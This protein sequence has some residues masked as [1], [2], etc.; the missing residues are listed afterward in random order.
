M[1]CEVDMKIDD[2]GIKEKTGQLFLVLGDL[3][4]PD[5]LLSM[6]R[7]RHIGGVLFRPDTAENIC[8]RYS[9]LDK[10]AK[11]PLLKAAN[12]ESGADGAV[13]D[14]TLFA[15]PMQIAATG[16]QIWA[17]RMGLS[18]V[19]ES[20]ASGVNITFSPV[21]DIDMNF[22]NPITNTRTFGDDT[23]RVVKMATAYINA[24]QSTGMAACVKHFPGDGVDFRDHHLHPTVNSLSADEWY[25]SYGKV[26]K[27]AI[28]AGVKCVMAGHIIQPNLTGNKLPG[29]LNK[30]LLQGILRG[31]LGF[32][33]VILSDAT[34]MGGF[35][36][37]MERRLAIPAAIEAGVDM[38]VFS[39]D[40]EEDYNY[41]LNGVKSGILSEERLDDAVS[42]ILALKKGVADITAPEGLPIKQWRKE[43][44]GKSITL[45]KN[46]EDILPLS[47]AKTPN[48]RIIAL[49]DRTCQ[50][51]DIAV[52]AAK[53][54][55]R[56]GFDAAL[57]DVDKTTMHGSGGYR[58]NAVTLYLANCEQKS[59]Q[60]VVRLFW[61]KRF[62]LD[63]PRFINEQPHIF[64]SFANPYHLQDVPR[65]RTYINAYTATQATIE[66]VIEALTGQ[67][68]FAGESPVDPFCG[69][70][71]TRW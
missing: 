34:I 48:V 30:D 2:M 49:G 33:G 1:L 45:V 14:G 16:D 7:D 8:K 18:C 25:A 65:I 42:R 17:E 55:R 20:A 26:Y 27:S 39:T 38:L 68:P 50:D 66:A 36:Q 64:V 51:G 6:V 63:M 11:I 58:D 70:P 44:A 32:D 4:S 10:A 22:R 71:D 57:F 13:S 61:N 21:A 24:V 43:C 31:R 37:A 69:L 52:I 53:L 60:T 9:P 62:A 3:Y 28:D 23:N 67:I 29:S 41:M 47:I 15:N 12:M 19:S 5:T 59:D 54:L 46:N 56:K 40:F 35:C